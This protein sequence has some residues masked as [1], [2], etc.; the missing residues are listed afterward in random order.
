MEIAT[1]YRGTE[2]T[3][4][5]TTDEMVHVGDCGDGAR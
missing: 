3:D 4:L 1:F 2:R 5:R